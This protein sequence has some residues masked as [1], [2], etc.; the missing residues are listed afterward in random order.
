MRNSAAFVGLGARRGAI[1]LF[2]R[3]VVAPA[4]IATVGAMDGWI[5]KGGRGCLRAMDMGNSDYGMNSPFSS[6]GGGRIRNNG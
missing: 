4:T 6:W 3:A 1:I 5:L 2:L